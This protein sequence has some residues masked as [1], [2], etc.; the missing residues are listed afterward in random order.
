[1]V[2][3]PFAKARDVQT[4]LPVE[5]A[6]AELAVR[7]VS[8]GIRGSIGWDVDYQTGLTYERLY[9][10]HAGRGD[11][12]LSAVRF[13][14]VTQRPSVI[15]PA[16][17]ITAITSIVVDG[18]TLTVDQYD[19]TKSGIVY[20][21]VAPARMVTVTYAAGFVRQPEDKAP[22]VLGE[23][24]LEHAISFAS[25]PE[26]VKSYTLGENTG[27]NFHER[28]SLDE[29]NRLDPWRVSLG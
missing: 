3:I 17:N 19:A 20:L 2:L 14:N 29:D 11:P 6:V 22:P 13:Q 1:M 16:M 12:V 4:L 15:L 23:V 25:N 8:N 27:E 5:D 24:C 28:K 7:T 18:N 9:R 26:N 21:G 10:G